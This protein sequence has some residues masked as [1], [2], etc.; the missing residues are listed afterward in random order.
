[1]RSS[2][3]TMVILTAIASSVSVC[4]THAQNVSNPPTTS[5]QGFRVAGTVVSKVDGH[6]LTGARVVLASTKA[7]QQSESVATSEDGKFEFTGVPAGKYSLRAPSV[8]TSPLV[9]NSTISTPRP[10]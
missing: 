4:K 3:H 7:R 1:M 9:T 10:S 6:P 2:L 5:A 8:D